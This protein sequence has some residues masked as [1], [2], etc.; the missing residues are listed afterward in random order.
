[1]RPVTTG[2]VGEVVP[3]EHL[4]RRGRYERGRLR[5]PLEEREDA[6]ADVAAVQPG[7]GWRGARQDMEVIGLRVGEPQ[8]TGPRE[9]LLTSRG[10]PPGTGDPPPRLA[11]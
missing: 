10:L 8:R 9:P 4:E 7:P 5:E 3:R 6:R 2:S 11:P 1:M